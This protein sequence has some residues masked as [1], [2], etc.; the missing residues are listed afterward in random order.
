M[1]GFEEQG[2][3]DQISELKIS[4]DILTKR[5]ESIQRTIELMEDVK[6]ECYT[7][8]EKLCELTLKLITFTEKMTP[9]EEA[10]EIKAQL[11]EE[12][13]A[14]IEDFLRQSAMLIK[15]FAAL[16]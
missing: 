4:Y 11:G 15:K 16:Q 8:A 14:A 12:N 1:Q 7:A 3:E 2:L 9:G 13:Q 10:V 6:V 5:Q